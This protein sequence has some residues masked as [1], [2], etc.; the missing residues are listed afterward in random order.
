MRGGTWEI[1]EEF[2]NGRHYYVKHGSEI[3]LPA[4]L[5][6]RPDAAA[7]IWHNEKRFLG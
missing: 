2:E 1:K 3:R 4:K 7:P 6:H 5:D